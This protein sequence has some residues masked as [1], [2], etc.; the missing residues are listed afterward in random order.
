MLPWIVDFKKDIYFAFA[1]HIKAFAG[2]GR[3][4]RF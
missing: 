1:D 3:R 2:G 4:M